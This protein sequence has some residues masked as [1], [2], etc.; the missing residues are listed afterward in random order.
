MR[1]TR[2]YISSGAKNAMY[3][4]RVFVQFAG[5]PARDNYICN[6][7]RDPEVAEEKA[8]AMFLELFA[9][10][11]DAVFDPT[12]EFNLNPYGQSWKTIREQKLMEMVEDDKFPYGKYT[13]QP[14]DQVDDGY[15]LWW[16]KKEITDQTDTVTAA[17]ITRMRGIAA[18]RK[19]LEKMA[20]KRAEIEAK[21]AASKHVGEVGKRSEMILTLHAIRYLDGIY[22]TVDLH[23]MEDQ[24]GNAVRWFANTNSGMEKGRT[25]KVMATVKKHD[26]YD[27]CKQTMVNR[28]K[29]I[30][31]ITD[32]QAA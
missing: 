19:V 29:V 25:Y 24:D 28:V 12:N 13:N 5:G 17:I 27:G 10:D 8:L 2:V 14:F 3:T 18:E 26:E 21:K 23:I 7:A 6:L 15:A 20:K 16:S 30:E 4:L 11:Q 32:A 22:G 31:E 9:D 1:K